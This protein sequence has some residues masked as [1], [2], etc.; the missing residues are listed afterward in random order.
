MDITAAPPLNRYLLYSPGVKADFFCFEPVSHAV[1]AHNLGDDMAK[2][3]LRLLGP[4]EELAAAARFAVTEIPRRA[5]S[6]GG[7]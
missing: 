7:C 3:G 1:E 5:F 2:H 6:N 4:G